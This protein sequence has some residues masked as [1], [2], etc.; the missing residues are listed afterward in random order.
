MNNNTECVLR[1]LSSVAD[2][3]DGAPELGRASPLR[4]LGRVPCHEASGA[5]GGIAPRSSLHQQLRGAQQQDQGKQPQMQACDPQGSTYRLC[6]PHAPVCRQCACVLPVF[7]CAALCGAYV[8]MR[9][10]CA[11]V[12]PMC[13]CGAYVPVW[14]P[15][16]ESSRE[17][18]AH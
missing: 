8:P 12:V 2:C 6:A 13:P 5:Q 7:L 4:I 3:H 1:T 16:R 9:C 17:A 15:G 18:G 10:L 11:C 14:C